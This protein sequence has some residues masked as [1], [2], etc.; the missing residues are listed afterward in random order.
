MSLVVSYSDSSNTHFDSR[1]VFH[2]FA[3]DFKCCTCGQYVVDDEHVC[4]DETFGMYACEVVLYA[5]PAVDA[6]LFGLR[7]AGFDAYEHVVDDRKSRH[8]ANAIGYVFCLVVTSFFL[9]AR[10]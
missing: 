7:F 9:F 5:K 3:A 8:F 4:A 10:M 2:C 6:V 1:N